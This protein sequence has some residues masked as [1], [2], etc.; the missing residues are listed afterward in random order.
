[1]PK[2]Y[3]HRATSR[4]KQNTKLPL[5]RYFS[6]AV[7]LGL[8]VIFLSILRDTKTPVTAK[9]KSTSVQTEN[10]VVTKPREKKKSRFEFY[11]LLPKQEV[12]V[13]ESEIKTRKREEEL[14]K[15]RPGIYELQVGS[16]RN[17]A[18]A[19]KLKAQLA[20]LGI[21]S[22][23]ETAK[24]GTASW[25]RVKLGPYSSMSKADAVRE[26]LRTDN[27]DSVVISKKTK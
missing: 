12:E 15:A 14:G 2:D 23:I 24:I 11:T 9:D 8:F 26:K 19:D 22:K 5:W 18:Q 21:T 17:F 7:L 1:M 3:K 27:I 25:N 13:P 6:I 4:R 20:F 16:F 10:S